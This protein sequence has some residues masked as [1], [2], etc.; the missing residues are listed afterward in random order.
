MIDLQAL[1]EKAGEEA[2]AFLKNETEYR[3]AF[4]DAEQPHPLTKNL[5][6]T[7]QKNTREGISM[8]FSVDVAMAERAAK[9]LATPAY[10]EFADAIRNTLKKGGRVVFSGCGSSGRLSMRLE[11]SWRN[12]IL[13]LCSRYPA[14][15]DTLME[16]IEQVSNIMTGGDYAIIRAAESFEDSTALGEAQAAEWELCE[17]DLLVG[18]TA[19][20]ETTSIL[21]TAINALQ[22]GASVWMLICSDPTPL[23]DKMERA[24]RVYLHPNCRSLYLDCG[25]MAITGSTRMQSSSYEQFASAVALE[26]ALNDLLSSLGIREEIPDYEAL[27]KEFLEMTRSL[28]SPSC[29]SLLAELTEKE[30]DVYE[31]GGLV[32]LFSDG[33]LMDVLTDTTER[34]PTF[35]TPPFCSSEMKDQPRSWAFVKNPTCPTN[36]AWEK[37]FLRTPRCIEWSRERYEELGLNAQ[38][39]E[40]I[41]RIDLFGLE[42]FEIGNEPAPDRMTDPCLAMWVDVEAPPSEFDT[43]AEGFDEKTILTPALAGISFYP[44]NMDLFEHLGLKM[45]LNTLSTGVMARMGRITGNWMTNVAMANKKLIDRSAR[46]VSDVCDISYER[47]MEEIHFSRALLEAE[48]RSGSPTQNAIQRLKKQ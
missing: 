4:L 5:S 20:G 26:W 8:L 13:K 45:M 2:R 6:Y 10:A 34:A 33:A 32:T 18:V 14:H 17:K 37:C 38:Q 7:Y 3:M 15:K 42:K 25:P 19:T 12:A 36:K 21:G 43:A 9:M 24:R 48:G 41:P 29:T 44:T 30:Q 28:G 35:M 23:P 1:K 31:K 16:K 22:N 47:A 46:I 39:I 40:R 27:G 11:Q